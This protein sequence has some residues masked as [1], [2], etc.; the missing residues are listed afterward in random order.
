MTRTIEQLK[1]W[2]TS[3]DKKAQDW[4][5]QTS[6]QEKAGLIVE[7]TTLEEG[8]QQAEMDEKTAVWA[9]SLQAE[10]DV[11]NAKKAALVA[12]KKEHTDLLIEK[13][14]QELKDSIDPLIIEKRRRTARTF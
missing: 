5:K 2:L 11:R 14:M 7:L 4:R 9:A 1:Y 6:N 3:L 12:K 8:Q 13:G 10:S